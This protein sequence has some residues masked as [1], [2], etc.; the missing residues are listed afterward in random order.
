MEAWPE[1]SSPHKSEK[2]GNGLDPGSRSGIRVSVCS[3]PVRVVLDLGACLVDVWA[4]C[5]GESR[6]CGNYCI[7]RTHSRVGYCR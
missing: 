4:A 6:L 5:G 3:E 7:E 2:P 1:L